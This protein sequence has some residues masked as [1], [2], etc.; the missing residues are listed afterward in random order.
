MGSATSVS[1]TQ[2]LKMFDSVE[3]LRRH[4]IGDGTKDRLL[5]F[6]RLGITSHR[7]YVLDNVPKGPL[8]DHALKSAEYTLDFFQ[9]LV[10][11]LDDEMNMLLSL[12]VPKK[13]I[14]VLL[15]NQVTV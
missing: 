8:R 9:A 12:K 6:L 15:S 1:A 14:I 2:H 11:H 3:E 13:Q 7:T 4:G 5:L 10:V